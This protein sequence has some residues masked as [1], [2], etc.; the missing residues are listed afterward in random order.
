MLLS[1]CAIQPEILPD[2]TSYSIRIDFLT[3]TAILDRQS[4]PFYAFSLRISPAN[5]SHQLSPIP[6][7]ITDISINT[8]TPH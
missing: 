1:C 3:P 4:Q 7:G 6:Q 8:G 5:H 2:F